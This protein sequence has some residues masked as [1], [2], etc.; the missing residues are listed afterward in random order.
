MTE[1][2]RA[3]LRRVVD[4]G[5]PGSAEAEIALGD[6]P[7][8]DRLKSAI[9]ALATRRG[10]QSSI[11]PSDAARAVGGDNWRDLTD[12]ARELARGLAKSGA[13]QITQHGAV[14]DA[15]AAW[16]GPIRIRITG[17]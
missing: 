16:R 2:L 13:V 17:N 7:I 3:E 1:Q 14:L 15:D 9:L 12:D 5:G 10:P 8:E 11:C 4:D 6:G